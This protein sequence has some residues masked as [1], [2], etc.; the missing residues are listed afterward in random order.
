MADSF[1]VSIDA[2]EMMKTVCTLK[3]KQTEKKLIESA[4]IALDFSKSS[5]VEELAHSLGISVDTNEIM[6]SIR[7]AKEEQKELDA[8]FKY[9]EENYLRMRKVQNY[10]N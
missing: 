2:K 7:A 1:G 9:I 6:R 5:Q 10:C 8:N 4:G 3:K